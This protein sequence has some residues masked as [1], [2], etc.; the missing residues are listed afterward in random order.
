MSQMALSFSHEYD[1]VRGVRYWRDWQAQ[2]SRRTQPLVVLHGGYGKRNMGDDAI[3]HV[4]L[5][6]LRQAMPA[7]RLVVLCHGPQ[8]VAR[9]Y[10]VEAYHFTSRAAWRAIRQADL[11]I[12]GGGGIINRINTYSGWQRWRVLDPKGKFLFVAALVA[13]ARGA[14]VVYHAIG[15]T[16]VPDPVVG[17]LAHV[18]LDRADDVSLR[19]PLSRQVL[20]GLGVRR[21]LPVVPDPAVMLEAAPADL[22]TDIL[23]REGLDPAERLVGL[24]LRPVAE[25]G[26]SNA[27]TADV[28]AA[29]V[30]WLA[31]TYHARVCFIP[32]G[33]HP[34]KPVEN[35]LTMANLIGTRVRRQDR[36][37]I[38]QHECTPPEMKGLL[39]AMGFCLLERL[40]AAILAASM[41]TPMVAL[42]YDDKVTQ[43]M[44]GI[45]AEARVLPLR[46]LTLR[47]AQEM[48]GAC[49]PWKG[50]R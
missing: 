33:M 3:L 39:G 21:E 16:S 15:A 49:I 20:R 32:F 8:L 36:F 22:V 25:P 41:G 34:R 1:P 50:E 40:H 45:G 24:N 14:R 30:D 23:R 9:A 44:A 31:D 48:I 18:A 7:A 29:L 5:A 12:I 4:L 42:A 38:L 46:E 10:N 43:F 35:D 17:W 11:Y 26:I 6:Q 37:R 47:R 19:D 2:L 13:G 28:A 27:V